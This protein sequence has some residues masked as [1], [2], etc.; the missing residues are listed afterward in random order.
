MNRLRTFFSIVHFRVLFIQNSFIR[1]RLFVFLVAR[2]FSSSFVSCLFVLSLCSFLVDQKTNI[3]IWNHADSVKTTFHFDYYS[4]FICSRHV[5][6]SLTN[7]FLHCC[8]R[9]PFSIECCKTKTNK[10]TYRLHYSAN[11]L[12]VKAC[13]N[14]FTTRD[15]QSISHT[16]KRL[17]TLLWCYWFGLFLRDKLYT[18][19]N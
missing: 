5:L 11:L 8:L 4:D 6:L 13:Y 7:C 2:A 9:A 18:Q 1:V 10:I 12:E 15:K 14:S 19:E 16:F 3:M 17:W